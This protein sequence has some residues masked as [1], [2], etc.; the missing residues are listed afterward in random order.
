MK[1]FKLEIGPEIHLY[2]ISCWHI[3]SKQASLK[4][5]DRVIA[6]IKADPLARW[7]Y[8]GDMGECVLRSS[9][10]NI[11]E[12]LLNPGDQLRY[13]AKLLEPIKDKGLFGVR[14]NHGNRLDK[15]TGLGWDEMFCAKVGIPY[16]GVACLMH[17][18]LSRTKTSRLA[19]S[20]FCH[21]GVGNGITPGGKANAAHKF[22]HLIAADVILVAHVHS[23]GPVQPVLAVAEID[24]AKEQVSW[25]LS[26]TYTT[27]SAYDSRSGYAEEK[28]YAPI[29]P[30]HLW[31]RLRC[32]QT[33]GMNVLDVEY[34]AI[35]G[36]DTDLTSDDNKYKWG[37][38]R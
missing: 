9:K 7:I 37:V 19:A 32:R 23:C 35:E 17:L 20:V 8:L 10:G 30:E 5:I 15:E 31:L 13:A 21:H 24:A 6:R 25:R 1:Y 28:G 16:M 38:L 27:G 18:I 2:P 14:G 4:F 12:Q 34:N 22:E 26:R 11:Y 3:G 36:F 33:K 29:L